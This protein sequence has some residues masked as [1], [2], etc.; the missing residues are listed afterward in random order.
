MCF[1]DDVSGCHWFLRLQVVSTLKQLET[2]TFGNGAK[3]QFRDVDFN[4]L[5][6]E[7]Q[8][9]VDVT[10]DIMVRLHR[11]RAWRLSGSHLLSLSL[12]RSD[13]TGLV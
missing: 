7:E 10:T 9:H 11:K 1:E 6:F 2:R 12:L 3:V 4:L 13:L 5:T 8:I